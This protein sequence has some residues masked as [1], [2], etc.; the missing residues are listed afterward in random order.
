MR[1]I[2]LSQIQ[3]HMHLARDIYHLN[4][5]LL[6]E[7]TSNLDRYT[8][9]LA[10]L[11]ITS[12][13][14]VDNISEDIEIPDAITEQTRVKCKDALQDTLFHFR[15]EGSFDTTCL[16]RAI[17]SLIE[18]LFARKDVL[19]SLTDIATTDD[20]TLVHSVSTT[21]LSL[22]MGQRLNLSEVEMR[23]L[24]EGALLHD[25]GKTLLD[26]T[27]LFKTEPLTSEEFAHIQ[28][29]PLL[30]YRALQRN[31]LITELSR[32]LALQHHER[33]DGSGYPQHLPGEDTHLFAKIVAIADVYDA[34]TSER[35]YHKSMTNHQAYEILMSDS[36]TKLDAQL[37][38]VFFNNIAIYPNGSLVRLS[39]GTRG[40]VKSQNKEAP[41]RPLIRIID[42]INGETVKL[43]DLDLMKD[44]TT[45]IIS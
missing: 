35:C 13:Y 6:R 20:N 31:P 41:F 12:I 45:Q 4:S 3:P 42:D 7:G 28:M 14:I 9:S 26:P 23:V 33:L 36:G 22:L 5:L 43:Y 21:V 27:I 38:H 25:I 39:N 40:I 32:L 19:I 24:A 30:G 34:L 44:L 10:N 11:G 15:T 18:D 1:R 2:P 29:H 17:D 16:S 37:L 8:A